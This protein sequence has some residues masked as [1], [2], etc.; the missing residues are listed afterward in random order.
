MSALTRTAP[1][2]E[3]DGSTTGGRIISRPLALVFLSE[4]CALTS[5]DLLLSVMPKYAAAGAGSA[6]ATPSR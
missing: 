2:R 3:T 5:F 6:A 1:S 4:F